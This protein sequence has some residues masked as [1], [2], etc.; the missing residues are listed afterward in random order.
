[1]RGPAMMKL[2]YFV[3][4]GAWLRLPQHNKN[5]RGYTKALLMLPTLEDVMRV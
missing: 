4:A 1:M 3:K 5:N 2:I